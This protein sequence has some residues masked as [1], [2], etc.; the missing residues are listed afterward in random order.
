MI[1]DRPGP[2]GAIS[3]I[4]LPGDDGQL[5]SRCSC[6]EGNDLSYLRFGRPGDHCL[7][8]HDFRLSVEGSKRVI[9]HT[10]VA[11]QLH[12]GLD[13]L[14]ALCRAEDIQHGLFLAL[15]GL[16]GTGCFGGNQIRNRNLLDIRR[17][18]AFKGVTPGIASKRAVRLEQRIRL[19]SSSHTISIFVSHQV[20][21][22][23]G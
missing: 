17:V 4:P 22:L 6:I 14:V 11:D 2:F 20:P 1:D 18:G 8:R 13:N 15:Q 7:G 10:L 23:P 19:L 21:G 5:R 9:Q 16:I 12:D 3:E